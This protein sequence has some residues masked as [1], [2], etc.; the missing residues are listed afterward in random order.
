MKSKS[1]ALVLTAMFYPM[2]AAADTTAE[3]K[4]EFPPLEPD[5]VP[6]AMPPAAAPAPSAAVAPSVPAAA[7]RA[8]VRQPAAAPQQQGYYYGNRG[9]PAQRGYYPYGGG[10]PGYGYRRPYGYSNG[11]SNGPMGFSMPRMGSRSPWSSGPWNSGSFNRG[12]WFGGNGPRNWFGRGNG[13][14]SWFGGRG[15][16]KE[17]F[18]NMWDDMIDAPSEMGTMPGGWEFPSV[19]MPNP[20]DSADELEKGSREF[21]REVPN[22]IDIK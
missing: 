13:P 14:S 3:Q 18:A 22:M 8:A 11:Y 21:V 15:G 12:N 20:V 2:L 5:E 10:R 6:S 9:Y 16:P 4:L 19:S 17:G 1:I 7:P